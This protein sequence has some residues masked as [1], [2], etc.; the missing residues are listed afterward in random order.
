MNATINLEKQHFPVLLDELISIISPL[1]GGTFIDCT[2]ET[3]IEA[4]K[5][6]K[7]FG[8]RFRFENEKF[9]NIDK[10]NINTNDLKAI[11]F[12]LGYSIS[13]INDHKKGLSFKSKGK[14]NMQL[15]KNSLSA[16]EVINKMSYENLNKIFKYFGNEHKS[17]DIAKNI[18]NQRPKKIILT[19]DLVRIIDRVKKKHSKIH[20]STKVFQSLRILVNNE[21]SQLIFGLI[22]SFKLLPVGSILAVVTFHSLEDKIVKYFFK[23]YSENKK[24]SRYLPE[25]KKNKKIFKII[26][27][28]PI[29]PSKKEINLN[30]PSRSAKL[31]CAR[32]IENTD[33]FSELLKKFRFL[34]DIEQ[35][36]DQI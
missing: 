3:S 19:E 20:K 14:L 10:L 12:D 26:N 18:I 28:K 33:D 6:I 24:G 30:P 15:G 25:T 16:H 21:I 27:K 22:N 13:Q 17:K 9:S 29:T 35:L 5:F 32:K 34:L 7:K 23:F 8:N 4:K 31:R 1:Y 36:S 2:F 11:I